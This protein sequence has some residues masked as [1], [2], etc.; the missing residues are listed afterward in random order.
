MKLSRRIRYWY[1]RVTRLRGTPHELALGLTVG[2]FAGCMPILPFQTALAIALAIP[3]RASKITALLGTW[4]SN[5]LNWWL[6]YLYS[7]KLGAFVLG[8]PNGNGVFRSILGM[9]QRGEEPMDIAMQILGA[10]GETVAAFLLGGVM[11][12]TVFAL[13]AYVISVRLFGF[14]QEVRRRR[15][16]KRAARRRST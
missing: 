9:I 3:L 7:H 6:L 14:F 5:P 12:G 2:V 13:P 10:G 1:W 11:I 15:R 4:V 16:E 8:I